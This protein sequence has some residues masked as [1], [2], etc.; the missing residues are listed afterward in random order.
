MERGRY[1]LVPIEETS[2]NVPPI[3]LKKS[4][5]QQ[6]QAP[7]IEPHFTARLFPE[8][9]F[10]IGV[11]GGTLFYANVLNEQSRTFSTLSAQGDR[12]LRAP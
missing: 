9:G 5:A 4:E 12:W 6:K 8:S 3:A 7:T 1:L 10:T 2:G 11:F